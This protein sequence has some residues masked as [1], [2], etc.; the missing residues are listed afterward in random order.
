MTRAIKAARNIA[1]VDACTV[2]NLTAN[3]LAPGGVPGKD[4]SMERA[5]NKRNRGFDKEAKP[6]T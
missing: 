2:S 4:D 1:G 3:L 6:L 5:C